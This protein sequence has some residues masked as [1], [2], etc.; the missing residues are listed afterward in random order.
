VITYLSI[1]IIISTLNH[2]KMKKIVL[3]Y[4][5][6]LTT[7]LTACSDFL[8]E[9]SNARLTIPANLNDMQALLE[10]PTSLNGN[11]AFEGEASSDDL[12]VPVGQENNLIDVD[13][14]LFR[15]ANEY[16]NPETG[17]TWYWCYTNLYRM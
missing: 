14:N 6:I 3:S 1:Q 17:N 13:E 9:K 7:G 10:H 12:F 2:K 4:L 5:I 8:D 15:F 11:D 16:I